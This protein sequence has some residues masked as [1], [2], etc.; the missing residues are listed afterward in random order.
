MHTNEFAGPLKPA[1]YFAPQVDPRC[2]QVFRC[3]QEQI[4]WPFFRCPGEPVR[5]TPWC[6]PSSACGASPTNGSPS[7]SARCAPWFEGHRSRASR[8]W[9]RCAAA[10]RFNGDRIRMETGRWPEKNSRPCETET[11]RRGKKRRLC[12]RPVIDTERINS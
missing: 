7:T 8:F 3:K 4:S 2:C 9:M 12:P 10:S 1:T 11:G 5:S 6:P